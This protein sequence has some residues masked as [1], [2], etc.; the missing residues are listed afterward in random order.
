MDKLVIQRMVDLTKE[1]VET[2]TCCD[3]LKVVANKWLT[4][5]GTKEKQDA[6]TRYFDV[7][8][9]SIVTVDDLIVFA[10][11]KEGIQ[12]FGEE[13]AAGIVEHGK[14]LKKAGAK[15]CDCPACYVVEQLLALK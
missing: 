12:K 11:S 6:T 1:L 8:E 7:L 2:N 5:L 3:E 9:E 10:G 14:E 13:T 15:Y 4:A